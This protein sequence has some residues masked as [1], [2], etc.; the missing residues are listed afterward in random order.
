MREIKLFG[1][2][3]LLSP[4]IFITYIVVIEDGWEMALGVWGGVFLLIIITFLGG[5]LVF[6]D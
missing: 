6:G 1:I 4:L 2:L 3:L 5:W